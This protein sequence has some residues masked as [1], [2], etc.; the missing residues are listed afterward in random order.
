VH[1][2]LAAP[3]DLDDARVLAI[4]AARKALAD[5]RPVTVFRQ[6]LDEQPAGVGRA[7]LGDRALA[8]LA[9]EECSDGTIPRKLQSCFGFAKRAK[10]ETSAQRPAAVSVSTPRKQRRRAI[11]RA[12]G[13]SGTS[14]SS[15]ATSS[16]RR[17]LIARVAIT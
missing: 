14:R 13:L 15:S 2:L 16:W 3:G 5:S 4:L 7:R 8:A 10:S 17:W 6:R 12:C 11:V 1:A 9:P